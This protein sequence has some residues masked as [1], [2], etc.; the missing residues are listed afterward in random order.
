MSKPKSVAL[1]LPAYPLGGA[2]RQAFVMASTLI[3]K[4][5]IDIIDVASNIKCRVVG[6][7]NVIGCGVDVIGLNLENKIVRRILR[8]Y[9]LF[10]LLF[11]LMRSEYKSFIFYSPIFFFLALPLKL[12]GKK[13][14]ISLRENKPDLY[15]FIS[16]LSLRSA[17]YIYTNTPSV[18]DHLEV[19]SVKCDLFL[20]EITMT[21]SVIKY[22]SKYTKNILMISNVEPHKR[23]DFVI[24][25][26]ANT[27]YTL[28]VCG[29]IENK[30]YHDFC[31]R[32]AKDSKVVVKFM[33][34][35]SHAEMSNLMT[36]PFIFIHASVVEGTSNAIL[37]AIN[38]RMP[39]LVSDIA[40][41]RYLVDDMRD[42]IFAADNQESLIGALDGLEKSINKDG[43]IELQEYLKY[44][45]SV[46]FSGKNTVE[47][48]DQLNRIFST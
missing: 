37:D 21:N 31:V 20:N 1:V 40:E 9:R 19:L 38:L 44:R 41:N 33:G 11:F 23:I 6:N 7:I 43:Y 5:D 29:R 35:L 32:A 30:S 16:R 27:D 26:L 13:V 48:V 10:L 18:K 14:I 42:F 45:V 46:K 28:T 36:K 25:S 8:Y 17:S 24:R 39:L 4:C 22:E 3:E 2:E 47:L 15:G 12:A 34:L